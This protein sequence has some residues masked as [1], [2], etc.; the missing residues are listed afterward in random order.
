MT[1]AV[2]ERPIM[3][4][5]KTDTRLAHD[6]AEDQ[7]FMRDLMAGTLPREAFAASLLPLQAIRA[8]IEKHLQA[9]A[10]H[11]AIAACIRPYHHFAQLYD[12]DIEYFGVDSDGSV[13]DLKSVQEFCRL[14]K[15]AEEA[16]PVNLLGI[17]YVLEGSNMGASML[18]GKVQ[19]A[20]EIEG[21]EG[22]GAMVPHGRDLMPRW[23]EFAG[24]MNN[25]ELSAEQREAILCSASNTFRVM[26][27]LYREIYQPAGS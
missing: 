19:A 2:D 14:V 20:Y 25:L 4:R 15:D 22:T 18:R 6:D 9:N 26:G 24:C 3:E 8:C 10:D 5:L 23:R 13:E 27:N 16:D 12:S 21:N 7:F 11:S 17:F 1:D